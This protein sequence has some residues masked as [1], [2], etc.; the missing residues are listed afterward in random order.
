M[1]E[2]EARAPVRRILV[3]LDAS[4]ASLAALDAAARLAATLEAE[5]LGLFVED[6]DLLRLAGLPFAREASLML[7]QA[8][9][10]ERADME[11]ALRAQATRARQALERVATRASVRCSF[12][13]VRGR[14]TEEL[15][16]AAAEADL[17]AVGFTGHAVPRARPGTTASALATGAGCTILIL[18]PETAIRPPV[19][20][21]Y[22]GS[23]A[24][25]HALTLAV[26]LAQVESWPL[27]LWIAGPN[28]PRRRALQQRAEQRLAGAGLTTA[29]RDW[30]DHDLSLLLREVRRYRGGTLVLPADMARGERERLTQVLEQAGGAVLLAR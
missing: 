18:P 20:A 17:V 22:D 12:R 2:T 23:A 10:V 8:R 30:E 21:V 29:V 13:V 7:A 11:R 6:V 24:A 15:L 4:G 9:R 25:R 27:L 3:A 5:L 28:V 16:A 19:M 1:T 26:R 14:V